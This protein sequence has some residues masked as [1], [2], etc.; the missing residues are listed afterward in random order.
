[1][2][3]VLVALGGAGLAVAADRPGNPVLRPE[4]TYRA[5]LAAQPWVDQLARDLDL[6]AGEGA[7]L[8]THGRDVLGSL[9]AL[10]VD[11]ANAALGRGDATAARI[12]TLTATL[13]DTAARAYESIDRWRL[14]PLW[15]NVFDQ[16]DAAIAAADELPAVW[17][18]LA[19]TGRTVAGIVVALAA[20]DEAVFQAT[21]FGRAGRWADAIALI[22]GAAADALAS[23]TALR[24][25]LAVASPAETLDDLLGR[26]RAYDAA[27]IALYQYLANGGAQ[28]GDQFQALKTQVDATQA[29]L[30][31]DN[32][33]LVVIV[34]EAAGR[35][36]TERLLTMETV[37]GKVN[38]A[39]QAITD[40][41][42]GGPTSDAIPDGTPLPSGPAA[43]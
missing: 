14:G 34:G 10:D 15:A 35:P 23:A 32:G 29:A 28:S 21:S 17:A 13:H 33:V 1:M 38:D 9:A 36:I 37:H 3:L 39:L 2:V 18:Q 41:K 12:A 26:E 11:A 19:A 30:P 8:S 27:L 24:D 6:V 20:H 16:I 40:A 5:D 4:L 43:P 7:Q 25:E 42:T 31:S 22:N